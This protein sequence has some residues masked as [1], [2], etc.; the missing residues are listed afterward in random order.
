MGLDLTLV[1]DFPIASLR[2]GKP[3]A[4]SQHDRRAADRV[5]SGFHWACSAPAPIIVQGQK[6]IEKEPSPEVT[7]AVR[8]G[9]RL[10]LRCRA[11][12]PCQ[13]LKH[14]LTNEV[15]F[16]ARCGA[17]LTCS[18]WR[19]QPQIPAW[20]NVKKVVCCKEFRRSSG[21]V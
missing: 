14:L 20:Q 1:G 9:L 4:G 7:V 5:E 10:N 15:W 18:P 2:G 12:F 6:K 21:V 3:S 13:L 11:A 17:I 19:T 8:A 16:D